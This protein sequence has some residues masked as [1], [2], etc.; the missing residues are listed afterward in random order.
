MANPEFALSLLSDDDLPALASFSCGDTDLDDFVRDDAWR[1][2]VENVAKTYLAIATESGE[3]VGY[4]T[5]L[6]DSVHL[7]TSEKK[8]LGLASDDH[9]IVPAVKIARLGIASERQGKGAGAFLVRCAFAL[10]R[11]VAELTGCRLLTVDAYP[12]ALPFYKRLG[13]KANKSP[14]YRERENPSLRLDV[15]SGQELDWV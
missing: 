11:E 14:S 5:L 7:L 15:F 12:T 1:L 9:P 8:K 3:I 13:F 6:T 4:F 2:Q 10:T